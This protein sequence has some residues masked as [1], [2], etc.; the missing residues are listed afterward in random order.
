MANFVAGKEISSAFFMPFFEEE[1]L[2]NKI[3]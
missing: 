1:L 3:V 2:F